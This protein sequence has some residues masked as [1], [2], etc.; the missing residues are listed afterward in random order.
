MAVNGDK[1]PYKVGKFVV[2][3]AIICNFVPVFSI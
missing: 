2:L 1:L 3:S